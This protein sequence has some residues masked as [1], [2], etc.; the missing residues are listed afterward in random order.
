MEAEWGEDAMDPLLPKAAVCDRHQDR[1]AGKLVAAGDGGGDCY[2]CE[3]CFNAFVRGGPLPFLRH[4]PRIRR[5][6]HLAAT[7]RAPRRRVGAKSGEN[8]EFLRS[9]FEHADI[10]MVVIDETGKITAAAGPQ[11]GVLGYTGE[12]RSGILDYVHPDDLSLAYSRLA[13]VTQEPEAQISLQIRARHSD[14]SIRLLAIQ[15]TN[16]LADPVLRG[17]V[18]RSRDLTPRQVR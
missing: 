5:R 10:S 18:I 1:P 4:S 8:A 16:R 14:G 3:E 11:G 6:G 9:L 2:L 7:R 17:L 15:L 12:Q 13:E